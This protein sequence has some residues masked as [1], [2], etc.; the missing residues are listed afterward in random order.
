MLT[1]LRCAGGARSSAP[2]DAEAV[3]ALA[4][5]V[6][7][8]G[9]PVRLLDLDA[10][11]RKVAAGW[12]PLADAARSG[13]AFMGEAQPTVLALDADTAEQIAALDALAAALREAGYRPVLVRSGR[14]RHLFARLPRAKVPGWVMR[15]R[16]AQVDA[17]HRSP[18]RPPLSPHPAGL[19]VELVG[20]TPAEALEALEPR[21]D[22]AGRLSPR[23]ARLVAE[24][25]TERRYASASEAVQAV[26]T[27]AVNAGWSFDRFAA[28]LARSP[29]A[30]DADRHGGEPW[31]RRSWTTAVRFVAENPSH[32]PDTVAQVRE[33]AAVWPWRGQGGRTDLAVLLAHLDA[34]DAAGGPVHVLPRAA[35]GVEA[36]TSDRTVVRARHRL[37]AAGWLVRLDEGSGKL[38]AVWRVA[39]PEGAR[40]LS[41]PQAHTP[42]SP[43]GRGDTLRVD[44]GHDAFRWGALGKVGAEVVEVLADA[45]RP[46]TAV[47]VAR[48]CR[49]APHPATVRRV[50][51]RAA[52]G[53]MVAR[54]GAGWVLLDASPVALEA[55]AVA[56]GTAGRRVAAV[57][58]AVRAREARQAARLAWV[59]EHLAAR[60]RGPRSALPD[61]ARAAA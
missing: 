53:R 14:G 9:R 57:D 49:T 39:V 13:R 23:M 27:G 30:A 25:D 16:A 18:I 28:E 40:E 3:E 59:A 36:A 1:P 61:D 37:V 45:D 20:M 17:R 43:E 51:A 56:H 32:A 34:A 21:R 35:A 54:S 41:P 22:R 47:E 58:A 19:P 12:A 15:A 48:R 5:A 11:G 29:F 8:P 44:R 50:L 38:A 42:R 52:E 10:S 6:L 31:L 60:R 7:M 26:A 24:G 46:L 33:L 55:V 4:A 2:P